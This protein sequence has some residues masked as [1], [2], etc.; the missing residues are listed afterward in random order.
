MA[1]AI[2]E[3][4]LVAIA[5]TSAITQKHADIGVYTVEAHRRQGLSTACAGLV[6]AAVQETGR[7]PTWST[8]EDNW[9]SLRVAEKLGLREVGRRVYVIP[10]RPG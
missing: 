7:T 3:G 2:V 4:R 8:G 9:A 6:A 5:H 1:G 10:G